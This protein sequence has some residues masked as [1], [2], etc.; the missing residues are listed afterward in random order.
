MHFQTVHDISVAGCRA[1]FVAP[2]TLG[3]VVVGVLRPVTPEISAV[4][5][6]IPISK[7]A[8]RAIAVTLFGFMF[9]LS[10]VMTWGSYWTL[11]HDL[12]I[13]RVGE[14]QGLVADVQPAATHQGMESFSVDGRTFSYARH[15]LSQG[16]D[17]LTVDGGPIANGRCVRI[18]YV[19]GHIL[20]LSLARSSGTA[21]RAEE[22]TQPW[23][24][25][26]MCRSIE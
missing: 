5:R 24:S 13:G 8:F 17:T 7:A 18:V 15:Q 12:R 9:L 4:T 1:W 20:R 23:L 25:E 3:L 14:V 19:R 16:F 22:Y 10:F 6:G 21:D 11:E 26:T 2:V